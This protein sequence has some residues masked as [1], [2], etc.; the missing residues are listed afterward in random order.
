MSRSELLPILED[1]EKLISKLEGRLKTD[2]EN[3]G[4]LLQAIEYLQQA[5][6]LVYHCLIE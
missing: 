5:D 1:I 2:P 6:S 3:W 4:Y